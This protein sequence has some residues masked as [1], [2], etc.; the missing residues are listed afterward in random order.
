MA[1][2]Y[3]YLYSHCKEFAVRENTFSESI[4]VPILTLMF[5]M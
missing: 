5:I 2:T 3:G 1:A 4:L